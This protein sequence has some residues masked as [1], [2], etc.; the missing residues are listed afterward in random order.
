MTVG[1]VGFVVI[2]CIVDVVGL[3]RD[4]LEMLDSAS[5]RGV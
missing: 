4:L 3:A 5:T 2:G 1:A